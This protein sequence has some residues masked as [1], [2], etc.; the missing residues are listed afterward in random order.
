MFFQY[1]QMDN[2]L[3]FIDLSFWITSVIITYLI[4]IYTLLKLNLKKA[5]ME[6]Y[7]KNNIITWFLFLFFLGLA[8]TLNIVWRF[9]I[10]DADIARNVEFLSQIFVFIAF[11][12]KIYNIERSINRSQFY[13][14]YFF[15]IL[16]LIS[17]II[18]IIIDPFIKEVGIIQT[19]YLIFTTA[20]F[21][22]F[23]GIFLYLMIKSTGDARKKAALVVIGA[24]FMGVGMM[25][26]PQNTESYIRV[27]PNYDFMKTLLTVTCPIVI[28]I[29]IL[30]IFLSY[31][32][33][34]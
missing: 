31:R 4:A 30:F 13:K 27:L 33:T 6:K 1:T 17:I 26:Q 12:I 3:A 28:T 10:S 34:I 2:S 8:N 9:T 20:G 29:G 32:D 7:Q 24:L 16:M 14:G 15:T 5:N 11:F 23:P 21:A 22:V 19:I 18:G 25:L